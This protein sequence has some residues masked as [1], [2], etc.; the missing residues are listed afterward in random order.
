MVRMGRVEEV[1]RVRGTGVVMA[2][3]TGVVVGAV[4]E[5]KSC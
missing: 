1:Q 5:N 3:E 2:Q 4:V